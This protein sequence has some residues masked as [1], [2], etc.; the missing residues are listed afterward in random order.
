MPADGRIYPLTVSGKT[1]FLTDDES[2]SFDKRSRWTIAF[3][4]IVGMVAILASNH[5]G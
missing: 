5:R 1:V 4:A 2:Y 3:P